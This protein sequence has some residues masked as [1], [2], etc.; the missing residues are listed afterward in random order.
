VSGRK[1]QFG[2]DGLLPWWLVMIPFQLNAL[3]LMMQEL[4]YAQR[5]RG[6]H[7]N[8]LTRHIGNVYLRHHL[9]KV[10]DVQILGFGHLIE[11]LRKL[12][13]NNSED[14]ALRVL[15]LV[16]NPK[17]TNMQEYAETLQALS[18]RVI[19]EAGRHEFFMIP[20]H[21]LRVYKEARDFF[22]EQ[23]NTAFPS[24]QKEIENAAKCYAFGRNTACV[25][26]LMRA[27]EVVLRLLSSS[28]NDPDLDPKKNPSWERILLRCDEQLK[29]PV[30]KRS[31]EWKKDDQFY[32]D[33]TANLRAVKNAWRNPT[34]HVER[35]YDEEETVD[36]VSAVRGFMK[37]TANKLGS[38]NDPRPK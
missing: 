7:D 3:I 19:D 1:S 18:D 4:E 13:L 6:H 24:A 9:T 5:L 2:S 8:L 36:V 14:Q 26:H 33:A 35:D 20:S 16:A 21:K 10:R 29:L 38:K 28:L 32:S 27:M 17:Q 23:V 15:E 25:F 37:H 31:P 22:G 34:M 12:G 30:E 11:M